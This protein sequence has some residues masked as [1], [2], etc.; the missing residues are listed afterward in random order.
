[1]TPFSEKLKSLRESRGVL[2]KTLAFET[3]V[4]S[5]YFSA[6]E[7]GRKPPPQNQE[8]FAK[9]RSSLQLSDE[10]INELELLA[11]TTA[12]L[13]LLARGTSPMQLEIAA[14]FAA[15]LTLLQPRHIRAIKAILD[16]T[17][18]SFETTTS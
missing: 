15:K 2:Q 1:M 3:G 18:P 14:A 5:T 16:L 7:H 17:E 4:S 10:E 11:A 6:L 8:F 13:G 9:L 12:T